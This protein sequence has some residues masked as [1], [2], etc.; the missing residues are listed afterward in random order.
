MPTHRS[1]SSYSPYQASSSNHS[2][3]KEGC[4][5]GF[6]IPPLSA[7]A[8]GI[9]AILAMASA[10]LSSQ[11]KAAAPLTSS[12]GLAPLY[13]AEV[14]HWTTRIQDWSS[15]WSL[16]PN[17]IATIM[18]IE[19]C[20]DPQA[21]SQAGASGLFQVMPFH[22]KTG[23]DPFDPDTNA[24][25]GLG[26]LKRSVDQANGNVRLALAGYNGGLGLIQ[27]N[28]VYWPAET[29]RYA[30]WG[31]A[32]YTDAKQGQ[33]ESSSLKDWL[34]HGGLRLC[35]QASNHLGLSN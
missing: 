32:I 9:L 2:S 6:L 26:Y 3:R 5:V 13:T 33:T 30:E 16:D 15:Q 18:Q 1:S 10:P 29:Q 21:A 35:R 14:Q 23:E 31:A 19:S 24:R 17:L 8:L 12:G 20:G 22:F 28:P 4:L 7:M 11:P 34:S 27:T 25:R